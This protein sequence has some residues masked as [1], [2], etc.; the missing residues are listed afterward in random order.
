[1]KL[2]GETSKGALNAIASVLEKKEPIQENVMVKYHNTMASRHK[3]CRC[4]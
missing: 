4:T 1:M 3:L 2:Y